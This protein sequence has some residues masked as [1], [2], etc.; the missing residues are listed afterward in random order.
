MSE[1]NISYYFRLIGQLGISIQWLLGKINDIAKR[2]WL[3]MRFLGC[4]FSYRL[5]TASK[6]LIIFK[7]FGSLRNKFKRKFYGRLDNQISGD[8]TNKSTFF[9]TAGGF[10]GGGRGGALV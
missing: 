8:F 5:S 2:V 10:R 4:L 3:R 9:G 7:C 1:R 6:H